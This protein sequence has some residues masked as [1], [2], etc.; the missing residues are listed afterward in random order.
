[1][2]EHGPRMTVQV[3]AHKAGPTPRFCTLFHHAWLSEPWPDLFLIC[4]METKPITDP[5]PVVNKGHVD[6]A[7]EM[8]N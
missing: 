7:A 8:I 2:S 1:M 5:G 6:L 3:S 4:H